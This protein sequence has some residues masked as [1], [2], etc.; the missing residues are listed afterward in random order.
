MLFR[1]AVEGKRSVLELMLAQNWSNVG[2]L[3]SGSQFLP[4]QASMP[5]PTAAAKSLLYVT[6]GRPNAPF[7]S[8]MLA[9]LPE[10]MMLST[11]FIT[12]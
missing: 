4:C 6:L 3:T 9:L 8:V 5:N 7:S 12:F 1:G 11:T 2:S 10:K